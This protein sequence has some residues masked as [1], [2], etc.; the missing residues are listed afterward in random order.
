MEE[1][2]ASEIWPVRYVSSNC[3]PIVHCCDAVCKIGVEP[4]R[5]VVTHQRHTETGFLCRNVQH[6]ASECADVTQENQG[7]LFER[8]ALSLK[9]EKLAAEVRECLP[10]PSVRAAFDLQFEN[11]AAP[12]L[13]DCL[14]HVPET[15]VEVLDRFEQVDVL[16]PRNRLE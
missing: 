15:V 9:S 3:S 13:G 10:L 8:T 14:P 4:L 7:I 11:A 2:M 16:E 1:G 12:P 6:R 5:R